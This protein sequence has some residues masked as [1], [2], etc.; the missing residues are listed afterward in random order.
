MTV[1]N[2][3]AVEG[4]SEV[5]ENVESSE[6]PKEGSE[7]VGVAG[8]P[9]DYEAW[10]E[11]REAK[12]ETKAPKTEKVESAPKVAEPKSPVVEKK[13]EPKVEAAKE[14]L[15]TEKVEEKPVV[16]SKLKVGDKE[17]GE[18]EIADLV[19]ASETSAKAVE[20]VR[21][22]AQQLINL[23]Q[24]DPAQ[25]FDHI[26]MPREAIEKWYYEHYMEPS[27][28]T[29]EQ[30]QAKADRAQLE[31]FKKAEAERVA[32]EEAAQAEALRKRYHEEFTASIQ[33]ALT[34]TGL[35]VTEWSISQTARY[36]SKEFAAGNK[37]ATPTSVAAKVKADWIELQNS[38]LKGMTPEQLAASLGN[39]AVAKLRQHDVSKLNNDAFKPAPKTESKPAA[40]KDSKD[41]PRFKNLYDGLPD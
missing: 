34:E 8:S 36:L 13:D 11:A 17:Y 30:R 35:P 25:I 24:T 12:T 21:A 29:P 10:L 15:K 16:P 31:R 27:L 19:K 20:E 1:E 39:E 41:K 4:V 5:V 28:L 32:K 22:Q 6:S 26:Q 18:T 23:L 2:T 3:G 9:S 7:F 40:K 37:A 33:N 14:A 38:V